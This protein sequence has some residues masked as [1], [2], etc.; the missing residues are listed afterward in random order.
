LSR[1]RDRRDEPITAAGDSGDVAG[2]F[3]AIAECFA[4]GSYMDPQTAFLNNRVGPND[5]EEFSLAD[6]FASTFSH[7][8]EDP[9]SAAAYPY[10]SIS[11]YEQFLRRNQTKRAE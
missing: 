8:D 1:Y 6:Y 2:I 4:H 5:I 9:E 7:G 3:S 11:S 10:R